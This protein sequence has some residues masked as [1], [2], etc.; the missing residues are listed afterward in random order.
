M[1]PEKKPRGRPVV[2]EQGRVNRGVSVPRDVADAV[3]AARGKR[4]WSEVVAEALR[5]WVKRR[6]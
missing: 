1:T 4:G 2:Y 3:D 6:R 5:A